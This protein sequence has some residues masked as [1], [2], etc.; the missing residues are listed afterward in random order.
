MEEKPAPLS[1]SEIIKRA[2]GP[3]A[4]AAAADGAISTDAVY[5]WPQIGIPDR[6]WPSIIALAAAGGATITPDD[7]M[8][9]NIAARAA[10]AG[11]DA[12]A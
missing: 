8:R 10:R 6:H 1:I 12:A 5:K 4:I 11:A 9:A 3:N 2:G 7:L